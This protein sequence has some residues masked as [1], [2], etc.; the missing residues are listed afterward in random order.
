[1][2]SL[3]K[4]VLTAIALIP[5]VVWLVLFSPDLFFVVFLSVV[6]FIAAMEWASLSHVSNKQLQFIYSLSIVMTGFGLSILNTLWVDIVMRLM[7]CFWLMIVALLLLV[8]S[9]I[10]ELKQNRIVMVLL[11]YVVLGSSFLSLYYLRIDIEG[12]ASLL[13]YLMLLIWIADSGAY[14][15]GRAFGKIKLSPQIS[16]GKSIEGVIGGV[17]VCLVFAYFSADYIGFKPS[18]LFLMISLSV[19]L[20]SV[21]GDLF[22]SLLK[23]RAQVKDSGTLLPGHGGVLDRIDSLLAA[24]PFFVACLTWL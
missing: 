10:L 18:L 23:R 4:R 20:V 9:K 2:N 3:G 14:F 6:F 12:G 15:S 1:M 21:Y 17:I 13:M 8:P 7:F 5:L 24:G 16:P 19:V 11:G 22:E